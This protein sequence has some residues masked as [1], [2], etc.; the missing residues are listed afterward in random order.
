M[1]R[2]D[3]GGWPGMKNNARLMDKNNKARR[4]S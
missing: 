3:V 1:L 4:Q 2:V